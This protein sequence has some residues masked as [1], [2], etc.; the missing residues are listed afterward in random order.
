MSDVSGLS[1]PVVLVV[2][3]DE[4]VRDIM[5]HALD[6]RGFQVLTAPDTRTARTICQE[7][8]GR[9]NI[10]IA[11]L[12][13]PGEVPGSLGHWVAT[14]YPRIKVVY[15][16]GIPRHV[17]LSSGLVQPDAPYL[18][19]PVNPNVLASTLRSLLPRA[20]PVPDDDW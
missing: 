12:S 2:E 11:D 4:D 17:A 3:D 5:A 19:K 6:G 7:R 20:T 9:I 8:S 10:L 14:A 15:A 1:L 16:S 13:L 18:E